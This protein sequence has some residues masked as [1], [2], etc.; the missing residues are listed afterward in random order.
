MTSPVIDRRTCLG[1]LVAV[2]ASGPATLA[3]RQAADG[4]SPPSA[5][6][7]AAA[8]P[9]ALD[10]GWSEAVC[11]VGDGEPVR[12]FASTVA[13]WQ[14]GE[15]VRIDP[16]L[17]AFM[18]L[19][20]AAAGAGRQWRITDG[21]G[22]AGALRLIELPSLRAQGG[23]ESGSAAAEPPWCTGG[24]FSVMVRSNALRE[25]WLAAR[26]LGWDAVTAPVDLEFSGVAIANVIL[27][28]PQGVNVSIYE[29]LSPRMPDEPDLLKLRRPFNSMQV[30]ADLAGA[31]RFYIDTLG[32]AVVGEGQFKWEPGKPN[33]FGVPPEV[34]RTAALD[35][36]IA[37]PRAGGPTQ[38]EIVHFRG[39]PARRRMPAGA[40]RPGVYALRMPVSR[41]DPVLARLS[42]ADW[43]VGDGARQ[44]VFDGQRPHRAVAIDSPEGARLEFFEV[45]RG[46]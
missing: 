41:L 35:Y 38:V 9:D 31:R 33:N 24:I 18:G 25:R 32:F 10:A 19:P 5:A 23:A 43:P 26:A 36:L 28:G 1:A 45:Q 34:A 7:P 20:A 39:L 13:G 14:V 42:A 11:L 27:R 40:A 12:R 2:A 30:V 15:P 22:R 8:A 21:T 16:S 46:A 6:P 29:R 37:A 44:V 4:V 17:A 3:T